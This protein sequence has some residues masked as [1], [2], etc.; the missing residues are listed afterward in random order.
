MN[1]TTAIIISFILLLIVT[2]CAQLKQKAETLKPTAKVVDTR[3]TAINFD[4]ADIVFD[5]MIDNPNPFALNLAGLAYDMKLEKQSLV[6][7]T[8]GQ[9]LRLK[10]DGQSKL[11]VPVSL[12]FADLKQLPGK[13]RHKDKIVYQ[14]NSTITVNLPIIGNYDIHVVK[15]GEVPVPKLPDIKLKNVKINNLSFTSAD[16]IT[17]IEIHNPNAFTLALNNFNYKLDINSQTWG[18]GSISQKQKVPAKGAGTINIPMKL[19]LL[20]MGSAV[21]QALVNKQT[22]DYRL[23][24]SLNLDTGIALLRNYNLPLDVKGRTSLK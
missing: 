16:L 2:G 3:L 21:Y 15:T 7:G 13:L 4:K 23:K 19:D 11:E 8:I 1:K 22:L 12:K 20:S 17:T 5:L 10:A 14:L 18:H 9:G 6:S 24:G